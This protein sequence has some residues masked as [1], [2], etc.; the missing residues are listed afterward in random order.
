MKLGGIF[1]LDSKNKALKTLKDKTLEINFW[2]DSQ[3]A[4]KCLKKIALIEKEIKD[5]LLGKFEKKTEI[6]VQDKNQGLD[7]EIMGSFSSKVHAK[8]DVKTE[9]DHKDDKVLVNHEWV[10]HKFSCKKC[11]KSCSTQQA[12]N[13]HLK[14]HEDKKYSCK[15]CPSMFHRHEHLQNHQKSQSY[16]QDLFLSKDKDHPQR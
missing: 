5:P 4:S 6:F 9:P 2:E 8:S 7:Q 12:L 16:H 14:I 3:H 1:D 15:F 13:R 10:I 11:I